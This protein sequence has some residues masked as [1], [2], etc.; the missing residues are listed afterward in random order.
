MIECDRLIVRLNCYRRCCRVVGRNCFADNVVIAED[1][2]ILGTR[3]TFPAETLRERALAR[4]T[5]LRSHVMRPVIE[6]AAGD[7]TFSRNCI[8]EDASRGL[9]RV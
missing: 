8:R 9:G 6:T 2:I 1:A 4:S 7:S 5:A 3:R